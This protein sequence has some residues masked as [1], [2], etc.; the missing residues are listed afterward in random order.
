MEEPLVIKSAQGVGR[1]E[2]SNQ[3][4]ANSLR[5]VEHFVATLRV[6]GLHAA[7]RVYTPPFCGGPQ[8][9]AQFFDDLAVNW[10]GWV[11]ARDWSSLEGEIKI[12]CTSDKLGHVEM[13]ILLRSSLLPLNWEASGTL[14]VEAGQL[15]SV[16]RA[17]RKFLHA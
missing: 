8:D 1:L 2:L 11:G 17:V 15:E 13:G 9:L 4:P 7:T 6:E 12:S 10:R 5:P 3:E 16:A 14:I